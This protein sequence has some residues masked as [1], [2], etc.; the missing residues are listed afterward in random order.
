M[1]FKLKKITGNQLFTPAIL[2]LSVLIGFYISSID[3]VEKNYSFSFI[4]A[5]G[6]II[7]ILKT[8]VTIFGSLEINLKDKKS[9]LSATLII[10]GIIQFY[11]GFLAINFLRVDKFPQ[12]TVALLLAAQ[13]IFS[14]TTFLTKNLTLLRFSL[15]T[16]LLLILSGSSLY[17]KLFVESPDLFILLQ[18]FIAYIVLITQLIELFLTMGFYSKN[19]VE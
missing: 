2:L 4:L 7:L 5:M 18:Q 8:F 11:L 10:L 17:F 9:L 3:L 16:N 1:S 12:N 6:G 14:I 13:I 19:R 15:F